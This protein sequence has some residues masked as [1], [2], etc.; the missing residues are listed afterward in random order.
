MTPGVEKLLAKIANLEN[1]NKELREKVSSL[2][3]ELDYFSSNNDMLM[4]QLIDARNE[5][6]FLEAKAAQHGI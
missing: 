2:T 6:N 1:E 4:E 5:I 3:D